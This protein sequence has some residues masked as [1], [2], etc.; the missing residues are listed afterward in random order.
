MENDKFITDGYCGLY[1]AACPDY[2]DSKCH[3]CKSDNLKEGLC[4]NCN[5]KSCAREKGVEFCFECTDYP[6]RKLE[7]FKTDKHCPYHTEVYDYMD[8]I[9]TRGRD[10]WLSE[11]KKRWSCPGCGK[12]LVWWDTECPECGVKVNGYNKP[13]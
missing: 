2:R 11:M 5:L 13:A 12:E 8:T 10:V 7:E 3:G 6:C 1:C 4:M 9:K